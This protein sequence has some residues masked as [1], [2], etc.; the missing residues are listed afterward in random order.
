M[1]LIWTAVQ[2]TGRIN[3]YI[4]VLNSYWFILQNYN[5]QMMGLDIIYTR[6]L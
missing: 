5:V 4:M 2:F 3:V 6:E 1:V